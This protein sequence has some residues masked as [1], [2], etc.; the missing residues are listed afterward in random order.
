MG[1]SSKHGDESTGDIGRDEDIEITFLSTAK[2]GTVL[3]KAHE[4][5]R[6][7]EALEVG[8]REAEKQSP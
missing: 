4:L 2:A 3:V 8:M 6:A 5:D 1:W 7:L